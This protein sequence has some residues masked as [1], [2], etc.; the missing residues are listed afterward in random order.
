MFAEGK[1][2]VVLKPAVFSLSCR[3][4]AGEL[5][6]PSITETLTGLRFGGLRNQCKSHFA[7]PVPGFREY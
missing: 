3:A 5:L 1:E 7:H 2:D 6:H 4:A